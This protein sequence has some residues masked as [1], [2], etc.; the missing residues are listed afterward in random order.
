MH[1]VHYNIVTG[2]KFATFHRKPNFRVTFSK[3]SHD[4]SKR[5]CKKCFIKIKKKKKKKRKEEKLIFTMIIVFNHMIS[6]VN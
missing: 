5:I 1:Y 4:V 2:Y 6:F 3:V